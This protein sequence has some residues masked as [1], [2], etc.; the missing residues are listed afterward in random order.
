MSLGGSTMSHHARA[1]TESS[2][3]GR[4][5][6]TLG[7]GDREPGHGVMKLRGQSNQ[8]CPGLATRAVPRSSCPAGCGDCGRETAGR[9]AETAYRLEDPAVLFM[10]RVAR[11]LAGGVILWDL[12]RQQLR[13][14]PAMCRLLHGTWAASTCLREV[15]DALAARFFDG[16]ILRRELEFL[17]MPTTE[18]RSIESVCRQG[19]HVYR[20]STGPLLDVTGKLAG[21]IQVYQDITAEREECARAA[22]VA[23]AGQAVVEAPDLLGAMSSLGT[24]LS[25]Q[26]ATDWMWLYTP[27]ATGWEMAAAW[28]RPGRP[29]VSWEGAF[30]HPSPHPAILTGLARGEAGGGPVAWARVPLVHRG[31]LTGYWCL[32]SRQRGAFAHSG[33][34]I[35]E[36][37]SAFL[38]CAVSAATARLQA[39]AMYQS[40]IEVLAAM[41]DA[42]DRYTMDHS[43]N[44]S[45]YATAIARVMGLPQDEISKITHA[46]LVHDIGKVGIP[47][48][49]LQKP[50]RLDAAERAVMMTHSAAGAA[51]LACSGAL[52][53]LAPLVRH[54]HEWHGGG[55]YPGGLAGDDIPLGCAILAVADAFDTMTSYRVYRP[56][57]SL[58]RA[59]A[60]LFRCGGEQF[61]PLVLEAFAEAVARA[62]A[63]GESWVAELEHRPDV[64]PWAW[65]AGRT[66]VQP[67]RRPPAPRELTVFLRLTEELEHVRSIEKLSAHALKVLGDELGYHHAGILLVD[68]QVQEL[69]MVA[70]TGKL[71]AVG[72]SVPRQPGLVWS[73]MEYGLAQSAPDVTADAR[74]GLP[75]WPQGSQV[76]VPVVLG[77]R[78]RGVVLVAKHETSAFHPGEV[79]LLTAVAAHLAAAIGTMQSLPK[80]T[81]SSSSPPG[82]A[83]AADAAVAPGNG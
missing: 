78:Q 11:E 46:G 12:S 83:V 69:V 72:M 28:T 29:A 81:L 40:T 58:D 27:G 64:P 54:H 10:D 68:H 2:A 66:L 77:G 39:D 53:E 25:P 48:R 3:S 75:A 21:R 52:R 38:A 42:R 45:R 4:A 47:D 8:G 55:G 65:T 51:I 82:S 17:I 41:V 50:G 74:C 44:V 1:T 6:K 62:R 71:G 20:V 80:P 37:L 18:H 76:C 13:L 33:A 32:G 16:E 59:M 14:S 70:A 34:R 49:I 56:A 73:V 19:L 5:P 23:R 24:M 31:A 61:H 57:R 15:G 43:R 60:E 35:L 7:P 9:T 22:R 67:G 26:L 30:D 79:R 63:H 36:P